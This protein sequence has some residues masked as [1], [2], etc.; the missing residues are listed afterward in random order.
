MTRPRPRALPRFITTTG[1]SAPLRRIGN[2]SLAVGAACAFS[3]DI[4]GQ[5][6]KFRTK[7]RLSFAPSTCRMPLGQSQLNAYREDWTQLA[8]LWIRARFPCCS[9]LADETVHA[10]LAKRVG[11]DRESSGIVAVVNDAAGSR[12]F[13]YGSADIADNREVAVIATPDSTQAT[14]AAKA[15][16]Q[17]I[18]IVFGTGGDPIALGL[19]VLVLIP[20]TQLTR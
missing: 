20:G 15:A 17:T 4:A 5:V 16:T 18:P 3:L 14:L 9:A 19:V 2:F 1:Q 12:L 13:T 6:L 11:I 10:I 8:L 7:A